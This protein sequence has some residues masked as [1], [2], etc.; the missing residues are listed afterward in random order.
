MDVNCLQCSQLLDG[1]KRKF[2]SQRCREKWH[3]AHARGLRVEKVCSR[4]FETY[5]APQGSSVSNCYSC[6]SFGKLLKLKNTSGPNSPTWKGGHKYWQ[7]GKT[8]RDQNGLSWKVQRKLAWERDSYTCQHCH[9]TE[10]EL[11]R[12][13]NVHHV[14]PY[15]LSLSHALDNLVSLC[16]SCHKKADAQ[17]PELWGG[18][19]LSQ[20]MHS[21]SVKV[22]CLGCGNSRRKKLPSGFCISCNRRLS[23]FPRALF[24]RRQIL[25]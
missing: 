8:G 5:T 22:S 25:S 1:R 17:I 16:R 2:C 19:T 11:G 14:K 20:S 24:L 3:Y 18:Q 21:R 15:R 9:K 10:Q 23:L 7:A 13:P 6:A 4:C 12:K